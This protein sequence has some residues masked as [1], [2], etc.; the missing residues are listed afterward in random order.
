MRV[1]W[2]NSMTER[3]WRQVGLSLLLAITAVGAGKI[4]PVN[5]TPGAEHPATRNFVL[6]RHA[7]KETGVQDPGLTQ[8]GHARANF[9]ADWWGDPR[10]KI[11]V[12]WSSNYRRTR[13]TA[14]PLAEQ[15]G[16]QIRIYDADDLPALAA[17]LREEDVNA[18]VIG[19][20]N[21]T[22]QLA[23]LLCACEV[24][25][26]DETDYERA[27]QVFR[28]NN[29]FGLLAVDFRKAWSDRPA[30]AD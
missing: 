4:D 11:E 24:P 7:E 10:R 16:V 26:M 29:K 25:P 17:R 13:E 8:V 14:G 27:Y 23:A 20:S 22:P 9:I 30:P 6:L 3:T 19:H 1:R 15:L 18:V 12:V 28:M 2:L 5:V 21:T